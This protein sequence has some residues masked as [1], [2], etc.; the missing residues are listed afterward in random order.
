[1]GADVVGEV[2]GLDVV[3]L[4]LGLLEGD[5]EGADVVGLEVGLELGAALS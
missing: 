1:M 3:G 4:E 5:E 2:E